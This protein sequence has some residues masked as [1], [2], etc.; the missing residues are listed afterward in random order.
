MTFETDPL[1]AVPAARRLSQSR[2]RWRVAAFMIAALAVLVLFGRFALPGTQVA[3]H[4]A[5]VR[6]DGIIT[7]NPTRLAELEAIAD[8]DRVKAVI[9][10]INSPGGTTAGGEEL[11]EALEK[12]RANKPVVAVIAEL[13]ASAAYMTAV[14][15][16]R[17]F[18][19]NLS[20]VGSIGVYISHVNAG[21]LME[22]IG[23]DYQKVQTGPLKAEP[24]INDPLSGAVAQSMQTLVDDSFNWFVD[25]VA[26]AR[27]MDRAA[28]LA[29]A[30]GR[31][32]SGRMG[33]ADGLI[34]A[35]GGEAEAIDWLESDKGIA[36]E[37][38][39]ITHF[40]PPKSE[41]ENLVQLVGGKALGL[42]GLGPDGANAL[43][44][45][46]SLWQAG[47]LQSQLPG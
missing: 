34:D 4:I 12:I 22:N 6:I 10:A 39:V 7:T 28:V 5:R 44:G 45:V 26:K 11:Y 30:D 17:I 18:A 38:P 33:I 19:R 31:I 13:G 27:H 29:L 15:T 43:D 14:A 41:L 16:D 47:Q 3:D 20:I 40:P 24:D 36:R 25:V 21:K 37:L 42:I 32:V 2:G 8:D 9:V 46:Q 35:A 23:I 1:N